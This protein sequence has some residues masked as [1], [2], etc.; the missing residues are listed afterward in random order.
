MTNFSDTEINNAD[1]CK[2]VDTS[3]QL[4]KRFLLQSFQALNCKPSFDLKL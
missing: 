3:N 2:I 1:L 4:I